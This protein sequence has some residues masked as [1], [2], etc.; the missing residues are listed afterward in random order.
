MENQEIIPLIPDELRRYINA[1]PE[2]DYLLVDV[3]QPP[4][5]GNAHIPGAMLLPLPELESKLF[6]LPPDRDLIFYCH[7]GG[8]SLAAADLAIGAEVTEKRVFHLDGGIMAWDGKVLPGFPRVQVF[9]KSVGYDALLMTAMELEKGAFRFYGHLQTTWPDAPFSTTVAQLALAETAH[10]RAVYGFWRQAV[11]D[12]PAFDDL[13][14]GLT[15]DILEG[16]ESLAD[17]LDRIQNAEDNPCMTVLETALTIEYAAYDLYRTM[18]EQVESDEARQAFLSISQAEK[19][20]MR[21]LTAAIP[22]CP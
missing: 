4:E 21:K 11:S 9:D 14:D 3:R 12:P 19:A 6:S 20:H 1:N 2:K 13:F 16:G 17:V 15:G 7:V 8:R 10:A 22:D 5:Y 18:A